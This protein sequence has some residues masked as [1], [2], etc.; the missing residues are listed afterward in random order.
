MV[1]VILRAEI[2]CFALLLFLLLMSKTYNMGKDSRAF[3]TIIL[4]ALVHVLLDAATVWT[5]NNTDIVPYVVNYIIHLLFYLSGI[6]FCRE[7]F[8]YALKKCYPLLYKK[9][10]LGSFVLPLVYLI[11]TPFPFM[12]IQFEE[13]EGTWSSVGPPTYLCFIFSFIYL[14]S[15]I[16]ILLANKN[17]INS[18]MKITLIPTLILLIGM[19]S[20]QAFFHPL[21]F[22]GGA[23][24]ICA[25]SFFFSLEN[26]ASVFR[27]K[28]MTDALT[29]M[30]SGHSYSEALNQIGDDYKKNPDKDK[31]FVAFCDIND[32]RSVNNRFGHQ[33]GDRYILSVASAL[34]K[35]IKSGLGIYRVGGDEFVIIYKN[36]TEDIVRQELENVQREVRMSDVE[37]QYIPEIA[38]GYAESGKEYESFSDIVRSADYAMYVNKAALK[39]GLSKISGATGIKTNINGLNNRL[40]DAL[41]L[42]NNNSFPFICNL[43]TKVTRIPPHVMEMFGLPDV[44]LPNIVGE[45][46]KII[47]PEDLDELR[48]AETIV[49][50]KRTDTFEC[51]VHFKKADGEYVFCKIY[52]TILKSDDISP[53][54]FA[55]YA[56]LSND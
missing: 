15:T 51:G 32:L 13:F 42:V 1:I 18:T 41:C 2:I 11:L 33:E 23:V 45:M 29:G 48:K 7:I 8:H 39:G 16:I 6:L 43:E 46:E 14:I 47:L 55:G 54:M 5:V 36:V 10:V 19:E 53:D 44:F 38:V 40:F 12:E 37:G 4:L 34:A 21:L 30:G 27:Q 35:H 31:Y 17:V 24:T 49:R 50:K 9:F 25:F 22:S 56:L 26:P 28:M 52:G 3:L 20:V